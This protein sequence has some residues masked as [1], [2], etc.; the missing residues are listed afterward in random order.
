MAWK[1]S[2]GTI[3]GKYIKLTLNKNFDSNQQTQK[4]PFDLPTDDKILNYKCSWELLC[5]SEEFWSENNIL[6][7]VDCSRI[8]I[9]KDF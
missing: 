7:C 8:S 9:I 3:Y 5:W 1:S 2:S 6:T 4:M